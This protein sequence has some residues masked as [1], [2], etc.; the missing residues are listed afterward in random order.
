[1]AKYTINTNKKK[2]KSFWKIIIFFV[3]LI[4]I[5]ILWT[6]Y[7]FYN[8]INQK[9]LIKWDV[10]IK[11]G[12][13]INSIYKN[14]DQV[15]LYALKYY[16]K[17]NSIDLTDIKPWNYNFSGYYTP[18]QVIDILKKWPIQ[19]FAH[20]TILEWRWIY[21]IDKYLTDN[22]YIT[23][24]D[25]I[26]FVTDKTIITKYISRYDFLKKS[27]EALSWALDTLEWF[28]YPD[29]YFVDPEKNIIDQL[30]Y[31]QL[32]TFHNKVRAEYKKK[33][34]TF[35][36]KLAL[37]WYPFQLS[38][39]SI[40]KLASVIEK[41]ERVEDQ[42]QIIAWIFLNRIKEWMR[43]DADVTLCYWLKMTYKQCT[44]WVIA[45]NVDDKNNLYNTRANK[46]LPKTPISSISLASLSSLLNFEKTDALFY[47]HDSKGLIHTA[48]TN[49]EH[50]VNKQRYL[51]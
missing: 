18:K 20:I 40:M 27:N 46:W 45:K 51:K 13:W 43:L 7:Y 5:W 2:K 41:E 32:D 26:N 38:I 10:Y 25:Y 37:N 31:V 1:M 48:I 34:S 39:Y 50:N 49:D 23:W 24:W 36:D 12:I 6:G 28:L 9:I 47:L 29:T 42:K 17:S 33:V 21:D 44:P 3:I 16:I 4:L 14:L 8:K 11:K 15:Q 35:N 19:K 22:S 30:V